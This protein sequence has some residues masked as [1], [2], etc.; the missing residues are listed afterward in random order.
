MRLAAAGAAI[1]GCVLAWA[2]QGDQTD[3][4]G[5]HLAVYGLAFVA[6]LVALHAASRGLSARG[7]R[8]ALGLA[9]LWR[10]ALVLAPPLLSDDIYRYVWEGRIQ[11]HGGNPYD[12]A[13]RPEGPKWT[14]L[15]DVT[16]ESVNHK[17]YT[18][19]YP[20][21]WQMAALGVVTVSDSVTAMKA[22]LVSCELLSWWPLA[23]LLRRHGLPP[24]RLL[25]TA[26]SP[27]AIVEIAGSGHNESF[28]L[29]LMVFSLAAL[30][31][32]RPMLSALAAA[33]GFQ[34]KLVPGLVAAA[35]G[36][37]YRPVQV[38][39]AFGLAALLIVPYAGAGAGLVRSLGKYGQYWRFNE[40]AF[41]LIAAVTGR[42]ETAVGLAAVAL[43]V[44]ALAIAWRRPDPVAGG[45]WL[46][47]AW[48]LLIPNVLPWYAVWLL[49]LLVLR[50]SPGAL[51]FTGTVGLAYLVYPEWRAGGAWHVGWGV[52][53]LEYLPCAAVG[54]VA[55][56]A[57]HRTGLK[58]DA[59]A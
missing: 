45:Q 23:A 36:R 26:W 10:L 47:I 18:A 13:D 25:V 27:L 32:E 15:R 17:E 43:A 20:P 3:R 35:W 41:A 30:E 50:D 58:P 52:R 48:L 28:G 46:I 57:P 19:I 11:L 12:W 59:E 29:L 54:A 31:A 8:L 9:A 6:Y 7:L 33:L 14:A 4:V 38:L 44:L 16:W 39:A 42:H 2:V 53:A 56:L 24:A 37:R 5:S 21:L 55:A 40:S 22:F 51:L 49:P 1:T 34:A